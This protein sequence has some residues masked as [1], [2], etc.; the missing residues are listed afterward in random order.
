MDSFTVGVVL[1]AG[2]MVVLSVALA[3]TAW[4]ARTEGLSGPHIV[5]R[6]LPILI[7][8][9]ALTVAFIAWLLTQL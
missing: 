9:T 1:Y 4:R 3:G 8:E 5:R 6:L 2:L 7:A